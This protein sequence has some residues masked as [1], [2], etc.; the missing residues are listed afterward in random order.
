MSSKLTARRQ[1]FLDNFLGVADATNF[2]GRKYFGGPFDESFMTANLTFFRIM[3]ADW[4]AL[5]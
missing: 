2:L 1:F 5:P 4:G 3:G